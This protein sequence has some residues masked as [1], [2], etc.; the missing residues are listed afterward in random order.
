VI[1]VFTET[2]TEYVVLH[3]NTPNPMNGA[4]AITGARLKRKKI[5]EV[6]NQMIFE[7][8]T[9]ALKEIKQIQSEI[10]ELRQRKKPVKTETENISNIC[11]FP[12]SEKL[13]DAFHRFIEYRKHDKHNAMTERSIKMTV[14]ILN[15][16]TA[17]ESVL[18]LEEA[19][20]NGYT[21]I[22]P[23]RMKRSVVDEWGNA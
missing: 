22:F 9:D 12:N 8:L 5:M 20:R 19:M 11:Y 17:E 7:V 4:L 2:M 21:G 23:K 1:R 14:N 18:A 10:S 3:K 15:K 16:F 6:T 13:D